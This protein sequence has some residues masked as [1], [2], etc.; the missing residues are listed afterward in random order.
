MAIVHLWKS[1][2]SKVRFIHMPATKRVY[3]ISDPSR[4]KEYSSISFMKRGSSSTR[5]VLCYL[6]MM[7]GK[8]VTA[9]Q[10]RQMF[11]AFFKGPVDAGRIL[12]TLTKRGF[13]QEV[14]EG[15]W[16]ITPVGENAI[17]LL[18]ARDKLKYAIS[19]DE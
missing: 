10:T 15:A 11:P 19:D 17:Y 4:W 9:L 8:P 5:S 18:A 16:R 6:K 7:R 13:A 12:K 3:V 2:V 1:C 14:Y